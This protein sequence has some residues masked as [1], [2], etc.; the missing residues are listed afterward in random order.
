M[1]TYERDYFNSEFLLIT[2]MNYLSQLD[3]DLEGEGGQ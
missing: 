3:F 2:N 1:P